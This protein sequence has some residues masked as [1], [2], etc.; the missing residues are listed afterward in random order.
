MQQIILKIEN[1]ILENKIIELSSRLNEPIEKLCIDAISYFINNVDKS[2]E[3]KY[4]T[5]DV[6]KFAT[7]HVFEIDNTIEYEKIKLFS[8]IK[9]GADYI[10]N[11]RQKT[12]R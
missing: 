4:K 12:W 9:N 7:K 5:F 1:Q 10:H 3:L 8:E 6:D 2:K 11:L